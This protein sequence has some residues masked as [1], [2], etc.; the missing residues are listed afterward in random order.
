MAAFFAYLAATQKQ[1]DR[2]H[3]HAAAAFTLSTYTHSMHIPA[4]QRE[5]SEMSGV[6]IP[7]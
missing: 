7:K 1:E 5:N 6:V 4:K 2:R 3:S